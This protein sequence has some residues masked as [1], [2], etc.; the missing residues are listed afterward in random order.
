MEVQTLGRTALTAG[1]DLMWF[2]SRFRQVRQHELFGVVFECVDS[3]SGELRSATHGDTIKKPPKVVKPQAVV[4]DGRDLPLFQND[5][6]SI[7][8]AGHAL[9]LSHVN[10]SQ[11]VAFM[12]CRR[13]DGA[14]PAGVGVAGFLVRSLPL[15]QDTPFPTSPV[16]PPDF[17]RFVD[18]ASLTTFV[19]HGVMLQKQRFGVNLFLRI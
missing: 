19:L 17:V 9:D 6:I 1:D 12:R 18:F 15:L 10:V 7:D 8:L 16:I 11:I 4:C 13:L 5:H 2:A 14:E 3:T